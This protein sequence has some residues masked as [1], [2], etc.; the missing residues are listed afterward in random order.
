LIAHGLPYPTNLEVAQRLE[1]LVR[2]QGAVPATVAVRHGQFQVGLAEK[3][4]GFLAQ[5]KGV[6]KVSLRDLPLVAAREADGATTVAATAIIA[7]WAGIRVFA[8]GGIGGVHRGTGLDISA[9]LSVLSTTPIIVVCAGAKAILDLPATLEWLETAGVP[10]LG[11]GTDEFPAFYS[12]SS[13]L[14]VDALVETPEEVTAI[15]WAQREL[16]LSQALL[17]AV[18]VPA[19]SELPR[20][21]VEGAIKAALAAAK[22]E[23]IRGRALTPYLLDR[24]V[25]E[26]GGASLQTNI[27]LLE[28]NVQRAAQIARMLGGIKEC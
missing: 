11:W 13:S 7:H 16:S 12:R 24:L 3:D 25:A 19:E 17:V 26:T 2:R 15:F 27:A 23:G 6:G 8:T 21:R 22:A 20:A 1:D 9:D 10:V 28:N 14:P 5:A 18:P 4:L